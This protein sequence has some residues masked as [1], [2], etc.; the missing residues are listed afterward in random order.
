MKILAS[1]A[2]RAANHGETHGGLYLIDFNNKSFD[3]VLDWSA[4]IDFN[5]R[6]AERG[7]R[8]LAIYKDYIVAAASSSI[9]ILDRKFNIINTLHNKYLHYCH[10]ICIKDN[11]LY[12]ISTG[13]DAIIC[14]D[15]DKD[16][17]IESYIVAGGKTRVFNPN[18]DNA[19]II[20]KDTM[21]LNN[22][23]VYNNEIYYSGTNNGSIYKLGGGKAAK[24]P[25]GTHNAQL[26]NNK[27]LYNNTVSG[28]I[29]LKHIDGGI[30]R[31]VGITKIHKSRMLN[32]ALSDKIAKQP[33]ARGLLKINDKLIGGSSP[34]MITLY[35]WASFKKEYEMSMM[36]DIRYTI[37][38]IEVYEL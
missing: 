18:I 21:H 28:S 12:V 27:V 32:S 3:K 35:D 30:I 9:L 5:G 10:E 38:G 16:K 19:N 2:V 34:A 20:K 23:S 6:G 29:T 4:E 1:S 25:G 14:F 31:N 37:H 11:I 26:I 36:N 22:V 33:F 24:I 7:L 15:L 8:G 17:F 13:Y